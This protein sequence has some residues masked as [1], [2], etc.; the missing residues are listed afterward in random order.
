[1]HQLTTFLPEAPLVHSATAIAI[2]GLSCRF[3]GARTPEEYWTNLRSGIESVERYSDE[4]LVAAGVDPAMFQQA[5]YVRAGAPIADMTCFDAAFFGLS[6]RDAAIIDPQHRHFLECSWAALEDA[7]HVPDRFTGSIGVFGGSGHNAYLSSNLLT[8]P[9]LVRDVGLFLLR[10]T[11]NDKDFLTT[12]V[13]YLLNLKGPSVNVQTACSTS[14]VAVHMAAQSLLAGECDMAIAGGTSIELPHGRGYLHENGGI[15]SPDGHCRPFD[16]TSAGTVFGSGSGIVV[17]RRLADAMADGDHVYA[18]IRGSA[19]NN[20]GAGKVGYLAPSM[21]GHAEAVTEAL[22]VAEIDADTIDYVEAHGTGTPVGDPIEVAAL[23]R[24]FRRDTD[25]IGYCGLGSVKANIGHT[26]T[27]AGTASL[28]KVALALDHGELPPTLNHATVNPAC[29]IANSPFK[30][31][32][33]LAPWP[34]RAGMPRRAGISALGV[35]GT[36]AHVVVEEAPAC[37]PG[38]SS[39]SHQI[40]PV[41]AKSALALEANAAALAEHLA[42][43][44]GIN[45]ADAAYTLSLGRQHHARRSIVVARDPVEAAAAFSTVDRVHTGEAIDRRPVS[46]LFSGGGSQHAGMGTDLYRTEPAF[47]AVVDACI[48]HAHGSGI[49]LGRWLFPALRDVDRAALE[50]ERPS[51]ALPALFTVQVALARLCMT[52]GVHPAG[53]IGHSLGEYAAAHLAGV[54]DLEDAIRLVCT[55]GR[56]FETLPAGGMLS[57]PLAEERLRALLPPELSVAAVN[58]P[59]LSTVSGPTAAIEQFQIALAAQD[60]ESQRVRI[61][62]AAHSPMLDPVLEEFRACV[63]SIT[64]HAPT[65][66]YVSTLTG[67]WI[68]TAEATDTNYWV[69]HWRETVRFADGLEH[70]LADQDH[71][72]LELGPGKAMA[73]LARQHP[74]RARTQPVLNTMRHPAEDVADMGQLLTTLGRLWTL[75][76]PVNWDAY[77]ADETRLRTPLPTYC[78]DRERHWFEP[79]RRAET[80]SDGETGARRLNPADWTYMPVWQRSTGRATAALAGNALVFEDDAG[81]GTAIADQLGA[82]G[83]RVTTVRTGRRF[84]RRG[85]NAYTLVP[86][87]PKGYALLLGHLAADGGLPSQIYHCWLVTGTRRRRVEALQDLG[88]FSILF[89]VQALSDVDPDTISLVVTTDC[90]QR[91]SDEA[92]LC[93][94]KATVLGACRTAAAE[95]PQLHIRCVDVAVPSNGLA[96]TRLADTLIEE[97]AAPGAFGAV[98]YRAGE[99][100][101]QTFEP[102]PRD[103]ASSS[104]L[105]PGGVYLMTGGLGGLCLALAQHLAAASSLCLGLM[106]R[107]PLPHRESWGDLI[108]CGSTDDPVTQII[109]QILAIEAAGGQVLL[110]TADVADVRATAR[111]VAALRRRFGRIDGVFHAA[112]VL[113]DGVMQLKTREAC[114]AVIAPKLM[115]VLALEAALADD[116]P[117]FMLLF[118]SVSA[119]AGL[120]GQADYAAGNAFL[121]AY[122]QSRR[123]DARTRVISVGWS[124][125]REIGMAAGPTPPSGP[126]EP[127]GQGRRLDHPLLDTVHELPGGGVVCTGTLGAGTHWVLDEHRLASGV[128][129]MPGTGYLE[130]AMAAHATTG[131]GARMLSDVSFMAPFIVPAGTTRDLRIHLAPGGGFAIFGR[132]VGAD[133]AWTE[134]ANGTVTASDSN[135]PDALC[136]DAIRARCAVPLPVSP[137]DTPH[138]RFGPRWHNIRGSHQGKDEALLELTLDQHFI[139]D[140]DTIALHPALLDMA[141]A[142]AQTLIADVDPL[143]DFFAP[144]G[145]KSVHVFAHLPASIVA[146]VR[147]RGDVVSDGLAVFDV[148]IADPGGTVLAEVSRFTMI[149]VRDPSALAT[150]SVPRASPTTRGIVEEASFALT[151]REGLAALDAILCGGPAAHLVVSPHDLHHALDALRAPRRTIAVVSAGDEDAPQSATE[152]L[153]AELWCDMLGLDRVGR[154][155]DFF[156]LGGHSLL[157][158]QFINRLRKRTGTMLP[159]SALLQSATVAGLAAI[160]DPH[161]AT[162]IVASGASVTEPTPVSSADAGQSGLIAIRAGTGL[163]PLFLVHDGL[164][165]TLL[166]RTLA[167]RLTQGHAVYG[168]EPAHRVDGGFAHTSIVAMAA[169][170]I[171]RIRQQYPDGP[172][173]IAG[174][175]AGGVIAFE[176]ARQLQDAGQSVPLVAILDAADVDADMRRLYVTRARFDRVRHLFHAAHATSALSL[177]GT[178]PVIL[179]RAANAAAWEIGSRIEH[180]RRARMVARMT[181]VA[182]LAP[183]SA[184]EILG[185]PLSFLHMYEVAHRLHRPSGL[186]AGGDVVLFKATAG[187]GDDDDEPFGNRYSDRV[188]GW[189]KRVADDVALVPVPGGHVT[190]L[191]DPHVGILAQHL[192]QAI[193]AAL[194]RWTAPPAPPAP[195][196]PATGETTILL[197]LAAAQ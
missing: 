66:P 49:D 89:L 132:P 163:A 34:R 113:D 84:A 27:A 87:D 94:A 69:R 104:W 155:Q 150:P 41:S 17:L 40:F 92:N 102:A 162:V 91:I 82:Q 8:N 131:Q 154:T 146:H 12:R 52:W 161:G 25:R 95:Y 183:S 36:N 56:L 157:A 62:V 136:L 100:W 140:L 135:E 191:R 18:V 33:A 148:T 164:G 149:K 106:A 175:C 29:D 158:I 193:D 165:E 159:L 81:I 139:A 194:A 61:D 171:G 109:A 185:P 35:G 133:T 141:S 60:I 85:R 11:G 118:S 187:G 115:G 130:I 123:Q 179:R 124:Q 108:A 37:V 153:I 120:A 51:I 73:S 39:R 111:A 70:L 80:P 86:G 93:P 197:E 7:G 2:V 22:A 98:A 45:I 174:L 67:R 168:I 196:A 9:A 75:G 43:H 97:A 127:I 32:T 14:L 167:H 184:A 24:A 190:L 74:K 144:I 4:Q 21:D 176:I 38:S 57:V 178:V 138:L 145:W 103:I 188:L 112:G 83:L 79:S 19:V 137:A 77:W 23:T 186:F 169:E 172:Y 152:Q 143:H 68:T 1:M 147:Y 71:V 76:V 192:Q 105:R 156:D 173:L 5:G 6:P 110:L 160:I 42:R 20:D 180:R 195:P 177:A 16:A 99:R 116:P 117:D 122:A 31:A 48:G 54:M 63:A 101:T 28:I 181:G 72:L 107:T 15:L 121:D 55:R 182:D 64:L 13:S 151:P 10:H 170:Y 50:I 44:P 88:F 134:H 142:G 47:A 166:Y 53:M 46:F 65:L 128:A 125:W 126:P 30:V 26:D 3:A 90:L 189:G 96:M 114:A 78:F 129:L 58:G 59:S 119:F